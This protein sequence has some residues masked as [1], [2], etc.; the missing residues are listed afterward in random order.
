MDIG[1]FMLRSVTYSVIYFY[2]VAEP[3]LNIESECRMEKGIFDH[4]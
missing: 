2:E 4:L 3:R 1:A